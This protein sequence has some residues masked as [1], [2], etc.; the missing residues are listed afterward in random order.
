MRKLQFL[1]TKAM[2]NSKGKKT[3]RRHLQMTAD[4]KHYLKRSTSDLRALQNE[5]GGHSGEKD[6]H[7]TAKAA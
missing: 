5:F 1:H 3:L 6:W 2:S 7:R 4:H